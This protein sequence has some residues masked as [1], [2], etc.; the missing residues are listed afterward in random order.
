LA[1]QIAAWASLHNQRIVTHARLNWSEN[2]SSGSAKI[3]ALRD[4][5]W[6]AQVLLRRYCKRLNTALLKSF[7]RDGQTPA[8]D[9]EKSAECPFSD[10]RRC[11]S[12]W[13]QRSI[14]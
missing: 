2:E 8:Q 4:A 1:R 10:F 14:E 5:P 7:G 6:L 3:F 12:Q 9:I 11:V 13:N